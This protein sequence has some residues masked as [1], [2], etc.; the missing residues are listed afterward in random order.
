[1]FCLI[2]FL[3]I[4]YPSLLFVLWGSLHSL[5]KV[6][7]I[8][9]EVVA[10]EFNLLNDWGW[11]IFWFLVTSQSCIFF[12]LFVC[13]CFCCYSFLQSLSSCDCDELSLRNDMSR[14]TAT[15][16]YSELKRLEYPLRC[17]NPLKQQILLGVCVCVLYLCVW[18]FVVVIRNRNCCLLLSLSE[19]NHE[20]YEFAACANYKYARSTH[21]L[22][23][24]ARTHAHIHSHALATHSIA[25]SLSRTRMKE[26]KGRKHDATTRRN[27]MKTTKQSRCRSQA[28]TVWR[29]NATV[30]VSETVCFCVCVRL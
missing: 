2:I 28:G 16:F 7:D 30:C 18:V 29:S 27:P 23:T 17:G 26:S 1:M 19:P 20:W 6:H 5:R 14:A 24:R 9:N 10:I 15:R 4:V 13:V 25:H 3:L 21:P 12:K 8:Q 22:F 11:G